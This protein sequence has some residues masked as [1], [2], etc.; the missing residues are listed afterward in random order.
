MTRLFL[1]SVCLAIFA[2]ATGSGMAAPQVVL[3]GS[4]EY[5]GNGVWQYNYTVKNYYAQGEEN[6]QHIRDLE[7]DAHWC[8]GWVD[9]G[10]PYGW[11][12][13]L[14]VTG[15][16]ARWTTEGSGIDINSEQNGFYIH[17]GIPDIY[18]G[19]CAFTYGPNHD[20]FATG[21]MAMPVP[22]PGSLFGLGSGLLAI[23]GA[24]LRRRR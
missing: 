11:V 23:V 20:V 24:F 15:P 1:A 22:E 18:Y 16:M 12:V 7:V 5:I 10:G 21:T 6:Q 8:Y 14:P 2:L 17:A 9:M 19:G 13:M 4:P 3:D